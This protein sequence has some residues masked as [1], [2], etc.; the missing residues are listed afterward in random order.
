MAAG[1]NNPLAGI[2][3]PRYSNG[4]ASVARQRHHFFHGLAIGPAYDFGRSE[5][6]RNFQSILIRRGSRNVPRN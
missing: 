6:R 5:P 3:A 1:G 4:Y 2:E